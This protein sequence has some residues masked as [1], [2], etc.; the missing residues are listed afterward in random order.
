M[1]LIEQNKF[2]KS[3]IFIDINGNV[4]YN[5]IF[6]IINGNVKFYEKLKNIEAEEV[7]IYM[8]SH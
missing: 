7:I 1:N 3:D 2:Y 8:M 5:K 4:Y 6:Q